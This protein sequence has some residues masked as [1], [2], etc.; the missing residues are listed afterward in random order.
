[1][2]AI[3]DSFS[4]ALSDL[5]KGRR[6]QQE[7]LQVLSKHPRVSTW[8]LS[9]YSWLRGLVFGLFA[10][11]LITADPLEPFPWCRYTLT[12]AGYAALAKAPEVRG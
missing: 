2:R 6:T 7:A 1:M 8:D 12:D 5:P 9:E 4:G 11:G 10:D 3:L